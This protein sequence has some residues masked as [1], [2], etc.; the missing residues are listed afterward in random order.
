MRFARFK[1]VAVVLLVS[2]SAC[3]SERSYEG[4]G[5][6]VDNGFLYME[7]GRYVLNLGTVS[8]TEPKS[9]KY[10]MANLP[11]HNLVVGFLVRKTVGV[12]ET[13]DVGMRVQLFREDGEQV[14]D[15]QAPLKE[16]TLTYT[17]GDTNPVY[18]Y[19]R[20]SETRERP[21]SESTV[22][23]PA[24]REAVDCG[25]G[26]YFCPRSR[27]AYTLVVTVHPAVQTPVKE[28]EL[29]VEDS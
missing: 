21:V 27:T 1:L 10:S 23:V 17:L 25:R 5:K 8:L 7:G 20:G 3:Y 26:T 9:Y 6:L 18:A 14:M 4:D 2:V 15:V 19:M 11:D 28:I 24:V 13:M 29:I 12:V 16:W 22:E